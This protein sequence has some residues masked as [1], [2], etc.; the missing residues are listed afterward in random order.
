MSAPKP[1]KVRYRE[2]ESGTFKWAE[3]DALPDYALEQEAVKKQIG[4]ILREEPDVP[5]INDYSNDIEQWRDELRRAVIDKRAARDNKSHQEADYR[6][7]QFVRAI[8]LYTAAEMIPAA[9]TQFGSY[10]A[11]FTFRVHPALDEYE[12]MSPR[13]YGANHRYVTADPVE[14]AFL[15]QHA[16]EYEFEEVP[17]GHVYSRGE[18]KRDGLWV[19]YDFYEKQV[20]AGQAV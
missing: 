3:R 5:K 12:D 2:L 8:D 6:I 10:R 7:D 19:P 1:K 14:I 20:A 11:D 13:R 17:V 15:R 9:A 4:Q 16:G 18:G